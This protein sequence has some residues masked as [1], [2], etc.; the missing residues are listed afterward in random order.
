LTG[1]GAVPQLQ[2]C[3]ES[4]LYEL[5][6]EYKFTQVFKG[7]TAA[8]IALANAGYYNRGTI[9]GG[10]IINNSKIS[11]SKGGMRIVTIYWQ[12]IDGY[13]PPDEV[14]LEQE[15]LKPHLMTHPA[16]SSLTNDDFIVIDTATRAGSYQGRQAALNMMAGTSNPTLASMLLTRL[17]N[18]QETYYFTGARL[19]WA[20]YYLPDDVPT[21]SEGG[22]MQ[23]PGGPDSYVLPAGFNWERYAD[24]LQQANY[25]PLGGIQKLIR[26]WIGGLNGWYT[27]PP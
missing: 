27:P 21:L 26:T 18:G 6:W 11:P 25:C 1:F 22:F 5:A 8:I 9:V 24:K 17:L 2:E 13:L 10:Y 20:T 19:T 16:Y 14:D 15:D 23:V 7:P 4:G 3:S 12:N